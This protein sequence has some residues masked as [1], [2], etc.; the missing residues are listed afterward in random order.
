MLRE[1]AGPSKI[2][3]LGKEV[4]KAAKSFQQAARV[5]LLMFVCNINIHV[6]QMLCQ[7]QSH[8][9]LCLRFVLCIH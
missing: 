3:G 5:S 4:G 6:L 8:W 7:L 1:C 9:T 2:P